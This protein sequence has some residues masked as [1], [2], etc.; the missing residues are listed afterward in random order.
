MESIFKRAGSAQRGDID[1]YAPFSRSLR[2]ELLDWLVT[3]SAFWHQ[4]LL[5]PLYCDRS[6]VAL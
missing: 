1:Q 3:H 5:S 6:T 4:S 2:E